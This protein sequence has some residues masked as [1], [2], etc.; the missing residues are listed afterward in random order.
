MEPQPW[1]P[2]TR[3]VGTRGSRSDRHYVRGVAA[4]SL[5]CAP[6]RQHGVVT[7]AAGA[8]N[9]RAGTVQSNHPRV[10]RTRC[11]ETRSDATDRRFRDRWGGPEGWWACG[12]SAPGVR[13]AV[14]AIDPGGAGSTVVSPGGS[15]QCGVPGATRPR[16]RRVRRSHRSASGRAPDARHPG[17]ASRSGGGAR[18]V[19]R[20]LTL[21]RGMAVGSVGAS[22]LTAAE[23]RLLPLLATHLSLQAIAERLYV[24]RNTVKSHVSSILRKLGKSKR[25]EA[26]Q[27]AEE[28][29]LLGRNLIEPYRRHVAGARRRS[30]LSRPE[31]KYVPR[32]T[33]SA[34][35]KAV[36][37][38]R[39]LVHRPHG[40]RGTRPTW[41]EGDSFDRPGL[42]L[43]ERPQDFVRRFRSSRRAPLDTVGRRRPG[44]ALAW[45]GFRWASVC[46]SLPS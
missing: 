33:E 2:L 20:A 22:A 29:G 15:V 39:L 42:G 46:G 11:P 34:R 7:V 27:V 5:S 28:I 24:S 38:Y 41:L 30:R 43:A 31:V 25:G 4:P 17:G 1:R 13:E 9:T 21:P 37:D 16:V 23:L 10:I 44:Q 40:H 14:G 26:A 3:C 19:R 12:R 36:T 18:A 35:A 6:R 8:A 32:V 45:I